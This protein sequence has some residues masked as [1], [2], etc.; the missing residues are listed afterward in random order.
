MPSREGVFVD[1]SGWIALLDEDDELHGHAAAQ[2]DE[3]IVARCAVFTTDWILAETGNGLAP[4]SARRFFA[5]AVNRFLTSPSG[6]LVRVDRDIFQKALD[7]YDRTP[8]KA[9]GLVDCASFEVMRREDIV[10]AFTA[11]RHFEQA[12]FRRLLAPSPR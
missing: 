10:N 6:R 7:M 3:I 4:T 2:F 8:D 5:Q 9:W 11:D 12:G 1:T